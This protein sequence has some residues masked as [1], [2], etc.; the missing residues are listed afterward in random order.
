MLTPE[1]EEILE[2]R[3]REGRWESPSHLLLAALRSMDDTESI[4]LADNNAVGS[5][6]GIEGV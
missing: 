4:V 1:V 3:M 5:G 2:R 6:S